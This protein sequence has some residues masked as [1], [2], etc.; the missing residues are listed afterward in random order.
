ML[1]DYFEVLGIQEIREGFR[2]RLE[3]TCVRAVC[4]DDGAAFPVVAS[5]L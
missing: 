5:W 1:G 4:V 3:Q 2:N